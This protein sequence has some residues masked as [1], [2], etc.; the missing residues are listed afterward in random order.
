MEG[1]HVDRQ[2]DRHHAATAAFCSCLANMPENERILNRKIVTGR[3]WGP[4][5]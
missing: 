4:M 1:A 3:F 5:L 2:T